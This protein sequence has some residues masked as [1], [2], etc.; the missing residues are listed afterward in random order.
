MAPNAPALRL[1]VQ[2]TFQPRA[3]QIVQI[4]TYS[5]TQLLYTRSQPVLFQIHFSNS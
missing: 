1:V 2:F 3:G 4:P 5:T